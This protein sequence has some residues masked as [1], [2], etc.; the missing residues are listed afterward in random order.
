MAQKIN[1]SEK[2]INEHCQKEVEFIKLGELAS[3]ETGTQLNKT[4]MTKTGD[5]PVLNGGIKHSGFHSE[6]NTE[7]NTISISQGGA[8]AGYVNF[9][10]TKFW[11]GAHC[12]VIKPKSNKINNRYLYFL[13]KNGQEKLQNAKLGAGIPGLNRK[14]LQGFKIPILPISVQEEIVKILDNFTEL[15]AKIETEL[16]S[17]IEARKKQYEHYIEDFFNIKNVEYK[18]LGEIGNFLRGRRFVKTDIRAEGVPCIHYGEMYTHYAIWAE[19]SKSFLEPELAKKL[20]VAHPGDVVIVAA[21][22][23]IEDIGR[24]VAWLGKSDVVVHDAC[25]IYSHKLNPKYVSYFLRTE[26]FHSQIKSFISSGKISSINSD[27]LARAKISIPSAKEQERIVSILD[28]LDALVYDISENLSAEFND[29]GKQYE[30][31]RNK[32]LSF[33][34]VKANE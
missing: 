30:Y 13:L 16:E 1:K 17:E 5:Y 4:A 9:V 32:M 31:Y 11:A 24:G 19:K 21:D 26:A 8:S 20:R 34:E 27:G 25:F 3:I 18:T 28:K 14:E 7:E 29:R 2:V 12:F 6:Y 33:N 23:T 15:E 22:E 10:T